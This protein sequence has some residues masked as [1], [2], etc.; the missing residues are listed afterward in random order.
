MPDEFLEYG[1][2]WRRLHP[3]WTVTDWRDGEL[4]AMPNVFARAQGA[5]PKDVLRFQADVARL[6]LLWTYGGVYVDCDIEPLR[7]LDGILDDVECFAS[8]SPNRGG[9]GRRLLTN[10]VLGACSAHPFIAACLDGLEDAVRDHAGKPVAQM[11]G[12]W[13]V[14]RVYEGLQHPDGVKVFD[15]GVF[16][17]QSNK[18]RDR[19]YEPELTGAYAWHKWATSRGCR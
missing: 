19:G 2:R 8:W 10:S 9:G 1:K 16:S 13:H 15:E 6:Q 5:A 3:K 4:P 17:P 12:P 11:V 7:P 18:D 14:T